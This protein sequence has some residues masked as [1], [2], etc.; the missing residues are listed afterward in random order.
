M[1][2]NLINSLIL[3]TSDGSIN[4]QH[5]PEKQDYEYG[6]QTMIQTREG[7]IKIELYY[8]DNKDSIKKAMMIIYNLNSKLSQITSDEYHRLKELSFDLFLDQLSERNK[9]LISATRQLVATKA[10][11][12]DKSDKLVKLPNP[13]WKLFIKKYFGKCFHNYQTHKGYHIC[14]ICTKIK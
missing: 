5:I 1:I 10:P 13:K 14:S 8:S 7:T 12:G 6:K 3:K 11:D 2:D 9:L 4:W